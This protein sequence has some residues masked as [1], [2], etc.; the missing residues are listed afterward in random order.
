MDSQMPQDPIGA[1][2]RLRTDSFGL[3]PMAD[4]PPVLV[5][6]PVSHAGLSLRNTDLIRSIAVPRG[7]HRSDLFGGDRTPVDSHR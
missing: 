3:P 2:G 1:S 5:L 7:H 6:E 4:D